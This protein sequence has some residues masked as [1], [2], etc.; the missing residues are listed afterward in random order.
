MPSDEAALARLTGD[1]VTWQ[2]AQADLIRYS[3]VS[4]DF[5]DIHYDDSAATA[6]GF[7]RPIAH[8]MLNVG[9]LLTRVADRLGVDAVRASETRFRAPAPVGSQLTLSFETE[10]L[11][12]D[13]TTLIATITDDAAKTVLT[14]RVETGAPAAD[15]PNATQAPEPAGEL[16]AER[17]LVVEQ[18]PATRFAGALG[19]TSPVF[20]R[21]DAAEAA[22]HPSIPVVPTFGFALPGWGFFPEL[23]GNEHADMPDAVR[24]CQ[25]WAKTNGAVIHASQGFRHSRAM[26][27]GETLTAR[28][29][30]TDRS[31]K[32]RGDR[33]LNFTSIATQFTDFRTAHVL[34]SAMTLVVTE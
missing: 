11:D 24:D 17:T 32:Q 33:V 4:R 30:V 14:S 23:P 28:S 19:A 16:V 15:S 2:V 8:G 31:I 21:K 9:L 12:S 22:G 26:Y 25:A 18:G 6:A 27:V 29:F 7:P 3:G 5:N 10:D 34:T 20:H 1:P 13:V